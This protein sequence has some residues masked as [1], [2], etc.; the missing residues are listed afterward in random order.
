M[1]ILGQEGGSTMKTRRSPEER[2]RLREKPKELKPRK[3]VAPEERPRFLKATPTLE[4]D[5]QIFA[6]LIYYT[7]CRPQE[8]HDLCA[9][10][11]NIEQSL[12]AI[13]CLKL[14][15]DGVFRYVPV[16]PDWI[17]KAAEILKIEK[18][19]PYAC[20]WDFSLRTGCRAIAKAMAA[21]NIQGSYANARG[22]RHSFCTIHTIRKTRPDMLQYMLGHKKFATTSI[23]TGAPNLNDE[24]FHNAA[25]A[26]W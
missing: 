19:D 10:D 24:E 13:E 22:L 1:V 14:R 9:L 5:R 7:G 8:A 18:R 20:V 15:E 23:Y 4:P 3:H 17:K 6:E 26:A 16:K 12:V 25:R 21:A 2:R 11:F